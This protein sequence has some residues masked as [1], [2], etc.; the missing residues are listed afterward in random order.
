MATNAGSGLGM[1]LPMLVEDWN[2]ILFWTH[3]FIM[4]LPGSVCQLSVL[5][6]LVIM[7]P[8]VLSSVCTVHGHVS[9]CVNSWVMSAYMAIR[10]P[11]VKFLNTLVLLICV[12]HFACLS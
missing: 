5:F 11:L 4:E 7:M 8:A 12:N 9:C 6:L 2:V 3:K 1:S 10:V